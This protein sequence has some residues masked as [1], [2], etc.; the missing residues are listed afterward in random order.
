MVSPRYTYNSFHVLAAQCFSS[1]QLGGALGHLEDGWRITFLHSTHVLHPNFVRSLQSIPYW[2]SDW[3]VLFRSV[4]LCQ[5]LAWF[6]TPFAPEN[7]C[8]KFYPILFWKDY[9]IT[10]IKLSYPQTR[11]RKTLWTLR[12]CNRWTTCYTAPA[13]WQCIMSFKYATAFHIAANV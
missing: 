13:W 7:R 6:Q 8:I 2:S 1:W 9:S 5:F 12:R 11:I 10:G 4:M 3:Q